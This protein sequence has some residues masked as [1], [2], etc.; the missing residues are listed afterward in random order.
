MD[1]GD[2]ISTI[3]FPSGD[4]LSQLTSLWH[5]LPSRNIS[6]I[7]EGTRDLLTLRISDGILVSSLATLPLLQHLEIDFPDQFNFTFPQSDHCLRKA[8]PLELRPILPFFHEST[9]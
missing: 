1:H 8:K 6:P 5:S 7:L 3:L 9:Q 2:F 4:I